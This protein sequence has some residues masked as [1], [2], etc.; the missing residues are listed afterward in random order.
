MTFGDRAGGH[1]F[2]VQGR[3]RMLEN[4]GAKRNTFALFF[5]TA[6]GFLPPFPL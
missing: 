1:L 6:T 4:R 5:V 3:R 2:L